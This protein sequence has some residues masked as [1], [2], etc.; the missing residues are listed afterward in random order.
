M[1]IV[2]TLETDSSSIAVADSPVHGRGV[3]A[4]AQIAEGTRIVE[5]TGQRIP[6]D[7]VADEDDD[8]RTYYFSIGDG[9][10]VIDPSIGG[11]DAR[12]INHSCAP[13]CEAVEE[14]DGRVFIEALRKIEPGEELFYDYRL[15]VD[16]RTPQIEAECACQCGAA[17]CRG[18]MLAI[19]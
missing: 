13:N 10:V 7:T 18:T 19:D 16:E 11:N 1:L 3:F 5:Y 8:P 4:C 14:D 6:W 9:S 15:Q 12:W 2:A 17:N